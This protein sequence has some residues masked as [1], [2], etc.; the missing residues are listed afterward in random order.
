MFVSQQTHLGED[1]V[2]HVL[3]QMCLALSCMHDL[4]IAHRDIKPGNVFITQLMDMKVGDF[5]VC[6]IP[7][8]YALG[9]IS[10]FT[11]GVFV[12]EPT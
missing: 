11:N 2:A 7:D 4:N 12:L 10:F 3:F 6:R 9:F 5:L 8:K 1:F